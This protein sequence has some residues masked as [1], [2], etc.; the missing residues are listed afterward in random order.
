MPAH[1]DGIVPWRERPDKFSASKALPG[2]P[3]M[4]LGMTD[5]A[6]I[7]VTVITVFSVRERPR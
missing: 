3:P 6:K 4:V 5:L 2:I 1:S 7:P